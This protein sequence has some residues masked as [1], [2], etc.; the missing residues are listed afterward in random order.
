MNHTP[1]DSITRF[2]YV[3][4][5][6]GTAGCVVAAR[7]AEDPD[8]TVALLEAGP[9]D[10]GDRRVLV[11]RDWMNLLGT[12]LDYDYA[13]E[14]QARGNSRIRHS[15]ARVLGGCSSHNGCVSFRAPDFDLRRWVEQGARGWGPED[16]AP[17]FQRVFARA[18]TQEPPDNPVNHAFIE[19]ARQAGFPRL[20]F[21]NQGD[22]AEGVGKFQINVR[23]GIRLS[24][25]VAYLHPLS[26]LPSNLQVLTGAPA[27][28]ILFDES[29]NAVGVLTDR[30]LVEARREIVVAC[31]AFD[32]PK[33][34]LLSGVGPAAQLGGLGI[35]VVADR[36]GVGE[37]LLDHPE[38]VVVYES[39]RPVPDATANF[40][41]IGLFAK[42]SA[43]EPHPDI[44]CHFG[45]VPFD[46][47]TKL[48]G[49]PTAPHGFSI[50]PNV[51]RSRSQ[52]VVRLRSADPRDPPSIDFR[53]YTD[54]EGYDERI[55][56][57]GVKLARRVAAQ[58]ALQAWI[59]RELAPGP[60]LQS[61]G[62]LSEYARLTGNTVYHPAGTCRMGDPS[63]PQAVVDPLLRVLG[64][65]R[66]RIADASIF[67][68]MT[69]V[70]PATTIMAI[71][72]RC[73]DLILSDR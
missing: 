59:E 27:R 19:A 25:S 4:V 6:G 64:V 37:H 72:E 20:T 34:L 57:A 35:P 2:D 3:I 45:L 28:R 73:A 63:D 29:R 24:S 49:Y 40:W 26:R 10:E 58:P 53:Y 36:P 7:L 18:P 61:D 69:S 65:Q 13:I 48:L 30:G 56:L 66:L 52:G 71:G 1:P 55:L 41:D 47:N 46:M 31:G 12:E 51:P 68:S 14:P 44:M 32:S 21:L 62:E 43:S 5:G 54:P 11:L 15:R 42:S 23:D 39:G 70:N 33:L 8:C 22:L 17:F 16:M 50:T 38:G 9:S 60:A 67:P